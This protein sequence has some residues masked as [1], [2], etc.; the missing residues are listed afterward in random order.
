M[1]P[2]LFPVLNYFLND[3][4]ITY[5][6]LINIFGCILF[7]Y[8]YNLIALHYNRIKKNFNEC[9]IFYVVGLVVFGLIFALNHYLIKGNIFTVDPHIVN[10]YPFGALTMLIAYTFVFYLEISICYKCMTDRLN[11][12]SQEILV[13][14]FSGMFFGLLFT[15]AFTPLHLETLVR[16]YIINAILVT[17]LSYSYN[18]T[19]S[20]IPGAL[21]LSTVAL[22]YNLLF[23]F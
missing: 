10:K 8:D 7:I 13:I 23:I 18:Q 20:F 12:K 16:T 15:V 17:L 11:I 4:T 3:E 1:I 22:I 6:V 14:L 21:A 5:T 9:A 19:T 2:V